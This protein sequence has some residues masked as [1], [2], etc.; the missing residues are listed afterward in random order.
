[1]DVEKAQT[2]DFPVA[3]FMR[4]PFL[5]SH[6]KSPSFCSGLISHV[7][8]AAL[9]TV[10]SHLIKARWVKA[11]WASSVAKHLKFMLGPDLELLYFSKDV[12]L[13]LLKT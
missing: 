7:I 8:P 10:L 1:M 12:I 3:L 11:D 2:C 13:Y 4:D 6:C 9:N 5:Q